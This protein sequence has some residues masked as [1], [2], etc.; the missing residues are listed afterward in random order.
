[1]AEP[2]VEALSVAQ[3]I[4][5][6]SRPGDCLRCIQIATMLEA[7]IDAK[8]RIA[9]IQER[10]HMARFVRHAGGGGYDGVLLAL[11]M[12]SGDPK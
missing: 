9:R 7:L 11:E 3:V 8:I 6:C 1:M 12:T 2:G 4:H 5:H 10:D